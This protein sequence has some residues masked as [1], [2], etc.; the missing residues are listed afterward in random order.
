MERVAELV[1]LGRL[2]ALAAAAGPVDPVA[3][4]RVARQPGEQVVED[5]LAD[6]PAAPRR[7]LEPV[8]VG[9]SGSRPPRAGGRARR[10]RR[11]RGPRRRRA[12]RGPRRDRAPARSPGA[13]DRPRA[14]SS[15]ASSAW[16]RPICSSAGSSPSGSLAAELVALAE[17]VGHQLVHVRRRAGRGP[18]AGGRRAGA[19]PSSTGA[20]PAAAASSTAAATASRPSAGS[21]ARRCRRASGRPGRTGRAC[22]RKSSTSSWLGS[23]PSSR[24]SSSGLRSRTISRFAA[25]SSGVVP[26]IASD[27]PSTNWSSVC[28]PEPL[29]SSSNRSRAAGSM[30]SYSSSCRIR[31][32]TSRGRAS[33][34]SSRRAAGVAEHRAERRVGRSSRPGGGGGLVQAALDAGPL[35]GDDLV[36]LLADVGQHVAELVALLELLAP[37]AEPLAQVLEAGQVAAGRVARPPAAL[38]QPAERLAEVAL[39]H[40]V[41]GQRVEDLVGVEGRDRLGAVPARVA[42]GPG[43][44][45]VA[46]ARSPRPARAAEVARVRA[47][48]ASSAARGRVAGHRR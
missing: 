38:H 17:A 29:D 13:L 25:S 40:D 16:S 28:L 14:A 18:S 42:G 1:R 21:A 39:G 19:R 31:P 46:A 37:A 26:W 32:P 6:P 48:A 34:W 44:Q 22:A 15:S 10:A 4:E 23:R 41:V 5:L 7:E 47:E 8:A 11:G 3:A 36:E 27:R 43:E 33:S 9:G 35:L 2:L 20:R 24:S 12:A 45:R 30:K